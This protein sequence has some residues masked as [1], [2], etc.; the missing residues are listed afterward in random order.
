M[1]D[2][3]SPLKEVDR[4]E[5][6]VLIDNYS[7][8]LLE[9][10]DIVTRP[11][12]A[13]G[14]KI[15]SDT[16]LAEHGLSLLIRVYREKFRH[17][18]L[19]D[20]G[21]SRIGVV[22]NAERLGIDFNEIEAIVVSHGHMDHTGALFNILSKTAKPPPLIVHPGAF[23]HPRYLC[24][25]NGRKLLLPRTLVRAELEAQKVEILETKAPKLIMDNMVMVTGEVKRSTAFEKGLTNTV[26]EKNGKLERD[27]IPDD[28][29]IV[30]H[31]TDR[32]MV[33]ISGCGHAG[34]VNT[35]LF[36]RKASGLERLYAVLG[37]LHF[38]GPNFKTVIDK[39]IEVLKK[40]APEVIV[41]MH[42]TG[43]NAIQRFSEAFPSSFIL[44]SVGSR[45]TLSRPR[46]V[47]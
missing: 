23:Q 24:L 14:D 12:R 2:D 47:S 4:V 44:N 16:L 45:F 29:A 28:Q 19:F 30:I 8:L 42:C 35:I 36:A 17:S 11:T 15:H 10:T 43:W 34:I 13:K 25:D 5:I 27:T 46:L 9:N 38:S 40:M 18:I 33:I 26:V 32:G 20:A 1:S 6:L 3:H 41:P 37:G 7:D 22:H 31:V 39:T 21:Y